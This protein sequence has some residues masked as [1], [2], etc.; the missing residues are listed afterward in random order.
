MALHLHRSERA[1]LLVSGLAR[2]LAAAPADPFTPDVVAVPS[3]GVERWIAQSLAATLGAQSGRDDGVCANVV[4]PSPAR[5]VRQTTAAAIGLDHDAD[6]WEPERLAW[7][8][9]A[10]VDAN[11]AAPWTTTLARHLGL[12]GAGNAGARPGEPTHGDPGRRMEVAQKFAGLF[13]SYAAHRPG[14]LLD[15]LAGRDSD[16]AGGTLGPDHAWQAELWRQVRGAVGTPSPAER[17]APACAALRA[18]P[19]LVD[20]P[21]RLNVFGPTRLTPVTIA[22]LDALAAHREV[23]LWLP[24]PSDGMWAR[25]ADPLPDATPTRL[26]T[27]TRL[28]DPTAAL[29]RHPLLRSLGRDARELQ[30]R[31]AAHTTP[32]SDE[33]LAVA[34]RP[35]TLLAAL[36]EDLAADRPPTAPTPDPAD[37][38]LQVHACH[39]R[40]RQVD[41]L[42]EAV[43]GL[44]QDDPTLEL[45]DIIVMCP[46]VEAFA[47]LLGGAFSATPAGEADALADDATG[48]AALHPSHEL[49]IRLADRS[50]RQVNPLLDVAARLLELAD[51][52]LTASQVLDLAAL[53]PVR[54]RFTFDDDA[55]DQLTTW[56]RDAGV[57]FGLDARGREPWGLGHLAQNTWK[58][59]LDRIL[60]GVALDED[61]LP[62][63]GGVLPLDDVDSNAVDLAGRLAEYVTSLGD[64]VAALSRPQPLAAW[65]AALGDAVA[66]LTALAPRDEW[67]LAHL[68]RLLADAVTAAGPR[69]DTTELRLTDVRALLGPELAPRPSRTN[70]RTGHLTIC[71]MVPMRSVP[72]RVVVLLGMDD[73]VFPRT[74]RLDGDDV[75]GRTPL[76]GE[77]DARAEDRQLFLDAL[78]AAQETLVILHTGADERTGAARPP[79][80]PVG[81]LLDVVRRMAPGDDVAVH[82]PLQPFDARNFTPP[83]P[84]SFD[85]AAHA[86]A[87]ALRGDR[88]PAPPFLPAPLPEEPL[89]A[90]DL[91]SLI[92][93]LEHPARHFLRTRLQLPSAADEEDPPE[94]LPVSLEAL[95]R[96]KVGD[97]VLRAVTTGTPL[98]RALDAEAVRGEVPPG[99]LGREALAKVA[100]DVVALL[101]AAAPVR[102]SGPATSRDVTVSLP[103]GVVLGG[104][105][106]SLHG[107]GV[108]RVVF[109]KLSPKHRLRAWVQLLALTADDGAD[110]PPRGAQTIGRNKDGG[111]TIATLRPPAPQQA[112]TLLDLLVALYRR[113]MTTPLP[114]A[115]ACSHEYARARSEGK[116]PAG[117]A[118]PAGKAWT[119]WN[120]Q[121]KRN[122]GDGGDAEH[123]QVWGDVPLA[124]LLEIPPDPA[125][126]PPA[127]PRMLADGPRP[128]LG[129]L[130][131]EP[132]LFGQLARLVWEPLLAHEG[133]REVGGAAGVGGAP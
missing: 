36:Q 102:G 130:R 15:W 21:D 119:I 73:G 41:V 60:L 81:E 46:D 126:V 113:G 43:L 108:V 76:V 52:R 118:W 69:A 61:G 125:L 70:F 131:E 133:I 88:A 20:L 99:S 114:L 56:A 37:R 121:Q 27:P 44:L 48:P 122:F 58:A 124:A 10:V 128:L 86:G 7:H 19:G 9:L 23:H 64:A 90:L 5:L 71:T 13:A 29:P 103:S 109:S 3:R 100:A 17:L 63:L 112:R 49:T 34:G 51:A 82:H 127:A 22:V 80:V 16:G 68:R 132:H 57:R 101:D 67:Q 96:W 6:P 87:L 105:V 84:F 50:P 54:R 24:H 18:D 45:R 123:L 115:P 42:R 129:S 32:S 2:L 72:H 104:T 83:R 55:L 28:A 98:Q 91:D 110:A 74:A 31:L 89:T 4:F 75:L 95:D 94:A 117:A 92:R 25:V 62:L 53:P 40:H 38:S 79:A 33:H 120:S 106:G 14:M 85:A 35:R 93:F 97:R 59:G 111:V 116:N 26:T 8:V 107:G 11:A 65:L 12:A 1:D 66:G 47:P 78:L 30:V 77:R 39:G